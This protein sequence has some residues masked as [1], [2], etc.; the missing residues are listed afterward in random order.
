MNSRRFGES[1][2][3]VQCLPR[4]C[5]QAVGAGDIHGT[6]ESARRVGGWGVSGRTRHQL[7]CAAGLSV[8][9]ASADRDKL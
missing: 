9:V 4:V 6:D 1:V 7:L 8:W 5:F 2:V 3:F